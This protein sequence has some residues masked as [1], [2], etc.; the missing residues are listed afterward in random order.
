MIFENI[1]AFF[2][3]KDKGEDNQIAPEGVCPNCW[4]RN[5]WE[6]EYFT[7]VKDRHTVPNKDVYNNFIKK[8]AD[9]YAKSSHKHGDKYI[10]ETCSVEY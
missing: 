8:V 4:G 2:S 3:A 10:C 9:K 5:E 1:K 6:D 7:I